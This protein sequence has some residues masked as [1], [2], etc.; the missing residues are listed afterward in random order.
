[1][2]TKATRASKAIGKGKGTAVAAA[3]AAAPASVSKVQ[4]VVRC[5]PVNKREKKFGVKPIIT[6]EGA[7]TKIAI[8]KGGS[9]S[10]KGGVLHKKEFVFDHSFWSVDKEDKH[11]CDQE[12]VFDCV[13]T[14]VLSNAFE[15]YNACIFAYGQTGSGTCVCTCMRASAC[16]VRGG[17][18][19]CLRCMPAKSPKSL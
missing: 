19:C 3:A 15:G 8:T 6:M 7:V 14:G 12:H 5:R 9:K 1:M 17:A 13:G 16:V 10:G 2:S 11:F 18:E 4:V